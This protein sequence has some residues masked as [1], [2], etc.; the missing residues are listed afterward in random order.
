MCRGVEGGWSADENYSGA[1]AL[2]C[3]G[4]RVA[5]LA[6]GS[7]AQE[8]NRIDGLAR[9]AS[10]DKNDLA[11]KIMATTESVQNGVGNCLGFCHSAGPHGSTGQ[12]AC[13]RFNDTHAALAQGFKI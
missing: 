11:G 9:T 1:T 3:F 5:H 13:S 7:V 4:N 6:A 2:C 8:S 10:R 12:Q